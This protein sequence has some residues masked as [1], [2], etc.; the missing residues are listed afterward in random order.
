MQISKN[1]FG[2]LSVALLVTACNSVDFKKTKAGVPY[3]VF[4]KGSGDSIKPNYIVKFEVIQKTK[5]TVIF[6]SYK[7]GR[8]EYMQVQPAAPSTNYN[9]IA[10]AIME[11]LPKA[12]KGD[13]I[14]ISQVTDS[15]IK[16][17]PQ[18]ATQAK[19]KKGDQFLTTLRIVDVYKSNEEAQA[20]VVKDRL[21]NYEE[22]E[23]ENLSRFQT[24]TAAQAQVARDNKIIE[25]YLTA[26]N[27]QT[28]KTPWG[29]YIQVL[30]PGQGAKPAPGQFANIRYKGT[31]LKGQQFDAGVYPLQI[32]LG[33]SIKGFEEGA[34]QLAKGGKAKIFI[35]SILAYGPRGSG[36]NIG[37]NENLVFEMEMLD[38]SNTQPAPAQPPVSDTTVARK[39]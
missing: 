4:S 34:K 5:D 29:V 17:N 38:I 3:K 20:A 30:N 14:L 2:V 28:Q 16:Q 18:L 21:A 35:P 39:R 33:G 24:D 37:P 26:N 27:I 32:G 36:P 15:L 31:N 25:D 22:M 9:D 1:V 7:Q 6:S 10:S 19:I 23:K 12:K 8:P 13:S 11:I